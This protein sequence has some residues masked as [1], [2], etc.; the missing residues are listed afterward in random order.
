MKN[1]SNRN[2]CI[3]AYDIGKIFSKDINCIVKC[4]RFVI[5]KGQDFKWCI[6]HHNL[7]FFSKVVCPKRLEKILLWH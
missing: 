2:D 6:P 5:Q 1:L 4:S 3:K 7:D